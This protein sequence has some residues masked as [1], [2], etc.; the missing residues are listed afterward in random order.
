MIRQDQI[1]TAAPNKASFEDASTAAPSP[2]ALSDLL[3]QEQRVERVDADILH[4]TDDVTLLVSSANRPV[5]YNVLEGEMTLRIEGEE[6]VRLSAGDGVMILFGDTH[7][8]GDGPMQRRTT[9]EA[10]RSR[11]RID[12]VH[13]GHGRESCTVLQCILEFA[14]MG[15]AAYANRAVPKC[16]VHR[17]DAA[18][19]DEHGIRPFTFDPA[20]LLADVARPG[21][22][23]LA[24]AFANLQLCHTLIQWSTFLW[25]GD[26]PNPRN[27]NTRRI[28]S[29]IHEIRAHPD[30]DWTVASM[31]R[32]CGLSRSAFAAAFTIATGRAPVDY[33]TRERM[34]K[35]AKLLLANSLS[36]HEI[37]RRVG[38]PIG[39]SFARAFH[40][41][42]GVAPREYLRAAL[43]EA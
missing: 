37:G 16:V 40:R 4:L 30:R 27:P 35:A 1:A 3:L 41:H 42:W 15:R 5:H 20:Q 17:A 8:I 9:N 39:G 25:S 31:A 11:D 23:A 36:M 19:A 10:A 6:P 12:H 24:T 34:E 29:V 2:V 33:L 26:C 38:Y 28:A 18:A 13:F 32:H 21:G 14:Y 43:G 7:R 22:L